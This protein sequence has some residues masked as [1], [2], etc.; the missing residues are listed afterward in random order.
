MGM[1]LLTK[2][3]IK[4]KSDEVRKMEIDEGHKLA[5]QI[6][7]IRRTKAE[8]EIALEK[9]RSETVKNIQSELEPLQR[10]LEEV[11]KELSDARKTRDELLEPL[12]AEWKE[13]SK[14]KEVV[15]KELEQALEG[16]KLAQ[17]ERKKAREEVVKAERTNARLLTL[18]EVAHDARNSAI[19]KEREASEILEQAE[20]ARK[21]VDVYKNEALATITEE[22]HKLD[23]R[24][25][26]LELNE[27][28][29]REE[30]EANRIKAIQ[31]E[32]ERLSLKAALK[33]K[34]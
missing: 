1:R 16:S 24:T 5:K 14:A 32:D 21:A 3:E 33:R 22:Q 23:M 31:L 13:V 20:I 9:F 4:N 7:G 8:E 15:E 30:A 34:S 18:E 10:E 29:V 27:A 6:A 25:E 2:K 12:D 26:A 28:R 19:I 11:K 17:E